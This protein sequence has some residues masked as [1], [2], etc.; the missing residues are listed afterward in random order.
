ML[1]LFPVVEF[2]IKVK[3]ILKAFDILEQFNLED[4]VVNKAIVHT[5]E[6][7]QENVTDYFVEDEFESRVNVSGYFQIDSGVQFE[8]IPSINLILRYNGGF[9]YLILS[10]S[11]HSVNFEQFLK[12]QILQ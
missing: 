12:L 4:I 9:E 6:G 2:L 3:T 1:L 7:V 10:V 11:E 5:L 8:F